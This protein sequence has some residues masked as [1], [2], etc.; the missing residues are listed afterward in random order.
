[1]ALINLFCIG[2][3]YFME[4]YTKFSVGGIGWKKA[5]R[6]IWLKINS[7]KQFK[8]ALSWWRE[9]HTHARTCTHCHVHFYLPPLTTTVLS[10]DLLTVSYSQRTALEHLDLSRTRATDVHQGYP[11]RLVGN[12]E[13]SDTWVSLFGR[14]GVLYAINQGGSEIWMPDWVLGGWFGH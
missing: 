3:T 7:G 10:W 13:S 11:L 8:I 4:T 9:R 1:M 12:R 5:R 14:F 6:L 2:T